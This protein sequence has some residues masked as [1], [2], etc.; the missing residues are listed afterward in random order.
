MEYNLDKVIERK[1]TNTYKWD[2][3]QKL[4]GRN[5]LLPMWVADMDFPAPEGIRFAIE[6]RARHGIYGYT[7]TPESVYE[8]VI[9]WMYSRHGWVIEREWLSFLPGVMPSVAFVI[10]AFTSPGD[11]VIVQPPVY[12]P[13]FS[14][15]K[16]NGRKLLENPLLIDT[17]GKYHIDFSDLEKKL[18]QGGKILLLCSPHNPV[19]RVWTKEELTEIGRLCKKHEAIVLSD[20]IHADLVFPGATH[21]PFSKISD[22]LRDLSIVAQAPSKSFNIPG[23]TIS[24][25]IIPSKSLR[26]RFFRFYRGLSMHLSNLF[27]T[28]ALEAAYREGGD[29]LDQVLAYI[30][31][32]IGL[33]E[34]RLRET[35]PGLTFQKPEGTYL[36][37][38]DCRRL[39]RDAEESAR[40]LVEKG[41]I[42]LNRGDTFGTGGEG[43]H[44]MNVA[45]PRSIVEEGCL[46]IAK[47]F[48]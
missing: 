28:T 40:L 44:R 12:Y 19:G 9:N 34:K 23:L 32:N 38:L 1:G 6:E 20:E 2:N 42:A 11:G 31:R 37:W 33:V 43:F 16:A 18:K 47:A 29:W 45:C 30:D 8:S 48:G 5:D 27:S 10:Q 22:E 7:Y 17:E 26:E 13:F 21:W 4:F 39:G 41:K 36:L 24:E 3:M 14:V 25:L 15:V 46:R 35:T